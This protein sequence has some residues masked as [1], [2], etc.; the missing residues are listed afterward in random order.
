MSRARPLA[1]MAVGSANLSSIRRTFGKTILPIWSTMLSSAPSLANEPDLAPAT[2]HAHIASLKHKVA[3]LGLLVL[4]VPAWAGD[5]HWS[6]EFG[7]GVASAWVNNGP[8]NEIRVTCDDG[9]GWNVTKVSFQLVGKAPPPDSTVTLIFDTTDPVNIRVN[10][11]SEVD[12]VCRSCAANF[13]LVRDY[14]KKGKSVYLQYPDHTGTRFTLAGARRAIGSC[15]SD[16]AK[17][18]TKDKGG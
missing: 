2:F 1:V 14:L 17:N 18:T 10:K 16:F 11:D 12:S 4:V 5:K 15:T 3:V 7:Q 9:A 13:E 8:G 6:Y